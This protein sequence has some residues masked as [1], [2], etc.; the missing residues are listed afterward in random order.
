MHGS[1]LIRMTHPH[2][3]TV[4]A[5][6]LEDLT[7]LDVHRL[8]KLRVD[9]FVHEQRCPYAGIDDHDA[10]PDTLHILAREGA[11]IVGTARVFPGPHGI[12]F[13]RFALRKDA[14]GGGIAQLIMAEALRRGATYLEAQAPLVDYY[15]QYGFVPCGPE[16]EDEGVPHVPMNRPAD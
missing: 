6:P 9:I 3:A 8:Y 15:S 12:H 10:H 5:H 14:R 13:G 4:T 11:D 16:F 1:T 7:A 2:P